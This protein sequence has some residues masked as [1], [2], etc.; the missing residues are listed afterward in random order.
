MS[1]SRFFRRSRWDD[2]RAREREAHLAH[3][4]DDNIASGMTPQAAAMAAHRR[5]GNATQI[6][7]D[8]YEMNTL[9]LL[10][11]IWQDLRYGFRL[12]RKNPTFSI[13][14]IL[15]LALGTGANAAIFQLVNSVRMRELPVERPQELA[16]I[17]I[18][19]SDTGRTGQ[20][21]NRRP[22]FTEPLWQAIRAEQ[23]GFSQLFA[24]GI[25]SWNLATDGEY[26]PA[27]G[28]YVTGDFFQTVGVSAQL[29]RVLGPADDHGT[30]SPWIRDSGMREVAPG[31][32][33]SYDSVRTYVRDSLVTERLMATLSGFFGILNML[34]A[35]IGLYGVMSCMVSRRK[36]EIGIRMALGADARSVVKM[37]LRESAL[38][39]AAGVV[40]GVGLAALMAR[41][42]ASLL[43]G[44]EPYDPLSF[45]WRS[46]RSAWSACWPHGFRRAARPASRRRWPCG[47]TD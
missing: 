2:E 20:F 5:L 43:F 34:I 39:L 38:L 25:T 37:V 31:A 44:L 21:S 10:E 41:W 13:V 40:V 47:L 42:A 28:L 3:E 6:R 18:D 17:G 32:T 26:L 15:T 45:L 19:T 33:V 46:W 35:T 1:W 23:Q 29:G 12:L 7:E 27:R 30:S 11:T 16:S 24:W 8:I 9:S 36:V 4:I 22:I 14:A